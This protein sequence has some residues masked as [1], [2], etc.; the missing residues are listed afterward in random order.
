MFEP[1]TEKAPAKINLALHVLGRRADGYHELDSAVAFADVGDELDFAPA[2][3]FALAAEGPFADGLPAVAENIIL[4]ARELAAKIAASRGRSLP[5]AAIRLV[6]NLPVASGIGGGSANGAAALRGL[7]R[8]GGIEAL[9]PEIMAAALGLG[10][11]VPVC[12]RATSCRM[13]GI[14]E[15]LVELP[16][17]APMAA[18]LVNPGL[19]LATAS[20]FSRLGLEPGES[21]GQPLDAAS[22]PSSWR[23]DLTAPAKALAP[24]ISE[25]L[26]LLAS[27]EGLRFARMSGSGATCFGVYA[28][29]AAAA[30]AARAL[31]SAR[32]RW[33]VRQTVLR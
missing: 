22:D 12:L 2:S 4:K 17:L 21:H 10:A 11:D 13:G 26:E 16:G 19:G 6:K 1:F 24:Q 30:M 3:E 18:V 33:W 32:P 28:S 9:D 23:N 15:R 31:A 25:V 14:G 27:G 20:V 8:L 7:L 29:A 5:G